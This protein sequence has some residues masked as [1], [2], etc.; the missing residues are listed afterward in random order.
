M[1]SPAAAFRRAARFNPACRTF[2][3]YAN[4]LDAKDRPTS[5]VLDWVADA[6]GVLRWRDVDKDGSRGVQGPGDGVLTLYTDFQTVPDA[7]QDMDGSWLEVV[8]GMERDAL[9]AGLRLAVRRRSGCA[10]A[11]RVLPP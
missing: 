4:T 5:A 8:S 3:L 9:G 2:G 6:R 10:P 1:T 7:V 11:V